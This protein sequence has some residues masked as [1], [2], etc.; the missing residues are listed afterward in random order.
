MTFHVSE[1]ATK[2]LTGTRKWAH[3]YMKLYPDEGLLRQE[4]EEYMN[5]FDEREA[6]KSQREKDIAENPDEVRANFTSNYIINYS[7][8]FIK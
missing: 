7:R 2:P 3:E 1:A 8:L 6:L 5:Q 4:C